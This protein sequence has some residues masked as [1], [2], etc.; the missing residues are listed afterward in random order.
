M[1]NSA[2]VMVHPGLE[3][4]RLHD[5]TMSRMIGGQDSC[6]MPK[7]MPTPKRLIMD[8]IYIEQLALWDRNVC[9]GE[10]YSMCNDL[11]ATV[12]HKIILLLC[13]K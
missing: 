5:R 13:L 2:T 9:S 10:A 8:L 3:C 4:L 11:N 1:P 6:S 7:R 12:S